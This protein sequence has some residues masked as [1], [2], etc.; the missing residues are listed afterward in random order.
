M[1]RLSDA[2]VLLLLLLG[3]VPAVLAQN[4]DPILTYFIG[5]RMNLDVA[6]GSQL[7]SGAGVSG[8]ATTAA[9]SSRPDPFVVFSNPAN[10]RH[11]GDGASFGITL[12]PRFT[13]GLP[14]ATQDGVDEAVDEFTGD[15]SEPPPPDV[16]VF[17]YPQFGGD[18]SRSANA[19]TNL[20]ITFPAGKWRFGFGY[21]RPFF[22]DLNMSL[23]GFSQRI[24]DPDEEDPSNSIAFAIQTRMNMQLDARADRWAFAIGREAGR[25][26]FGFSVART[27]TSIG[28]NGGYNIDGVMTRGKKQYAFNDT[29]VPWYNRFHGEI[30][31]GYAG[32]MYTY[33]FG[34]VYVAGGNEERGW[35]FGFDLAL[36]SSNMLY[37]G[38]EIA[39]D[40]FTPLNLSPEEDEESFDA[41]LIEDVSEITRTKENR[42]YVADDLELNVPSSFTFS[43]AKPSGWRPNLSFTT[44]FGGELG[45]R[46]DVREKSVNATEYAVNT[47]ARGVKPSFATYLGINPGIFFLGGGAIFVEDVVE[48]YK[49]DNGVPIKGGTSMPIPRLDLGL[50]FNLSSHIRYEMLIAG[51]PEDA[52]RIGL[53]YDF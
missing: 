53:V 50:A 23:G 51:L 41:D 15:F 17:S 36:N 32:S 30:G 7:A 3:S 5:G 24:D 12:Q 37:G 8:V 11:M 26:G 44:Y 16:Q 13:M 49:D 35:R 6:F 31:G 9:A 38:M 29:K 25:W 42:Y 48:G 39:I 1:K 45:Y 2:V 46:V 52:L 19:L 40:E 4:E 47:Y 10:L 34:T 21:T 33:R 20:A 22:L 43:I 27:Y 18:I 28:V 14:S